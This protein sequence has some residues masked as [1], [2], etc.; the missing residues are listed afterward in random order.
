MKMV[1]NGK[2]ITV[3]PVRRKKK[4]IQVITGLDMHIITGLDMVG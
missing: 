3:V 4:H 1:E 2:Q